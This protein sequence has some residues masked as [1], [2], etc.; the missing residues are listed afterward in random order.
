MLLVIDVGNSNIVIGIYQKEKLI[1]HWRVVT[2]NYRT[3]D[4]FHLLLTMLFYSTNIKPSQIRGCCISSVV[5]D[6]NPALI[7]LCERAFGFEP[8]MVEPGIRTGIV[9]QC[10]NPKEVGADRIVNAVAAVEEY[11]GPLVIVDFGTA[12]TFDVVTAKAEWLGGVIVPG[13]QLSADALFEHCAKLP[14]VDI[15][16]PHSVIGRDT[17]NNIRAGLTFGYADLVDGLIKR[18]RDELEAPAQ[19]VATGGL[20]PT[21]AQISKNIDIVDPLLTLKGLKIIFEKNTRGNA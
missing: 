19:A 8:L 12:T 16:I 18:I 3:G 7:H 10:D 15:S 14:R 5:P 20:A 13:I 21:I 9:L 6:V 1:Q 4:E 17:V 11:G 2:S